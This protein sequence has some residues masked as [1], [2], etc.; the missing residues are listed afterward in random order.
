MGTSRVVNHP[1]AARMRSSYLLSGCVVAVGVYA[2]VHLALHRTESISGI[3]VLVLLVPT[4]LLALAVGTRLWKRFWRSAECPDCRCRLD[5][6]AGRTDGGVRWGYLCSRCET[7][8]DSGVGDT[9]AP[10]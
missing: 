10:R 7:F 8:Y 6:V 4:F 5:L 3:V 2:A 9:K 1:Q